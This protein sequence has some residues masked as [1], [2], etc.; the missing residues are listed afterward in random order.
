MGLAG[1]GWGLRGSALELQVFHTINAWG[2]QAA[3]FWSSWSV[4]GLGVSALLILAAGGR[5][6]AQAVL[7][8]L[9]ILLLGGLVLHGAKWWVGGLRPL[10][11]LGPDG[12]HVVGAALR[13][14]SMPSGHAATA[15]AFAT[16]MTLQVAP[17]GAVLV[18]CWLGALAVALARVAVGAH[19]P[20]DVLAGAGLGLGLGALGA[21]GAQQWSALP[22]AAARLQQRWGARCVAVAL[23][24]L[25]GGFAVTDDGYPA[26]A[27]THA[28]LC[29]LGLWA[30]WVWWRNPGTGVPAAVGVAQ[31]APQDVP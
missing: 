4:L 23:V 18:L 29:V 26:A 1:L 8:F 12:L 27:G 13:H 20:S 2:P 25:S 30:A 14:G 16:V 6:R 9:V 21:Y 5:A 11:V 3:F 28:A 22:A 24:A 10:A 19:W 17:R 7:T 31:S 15:F